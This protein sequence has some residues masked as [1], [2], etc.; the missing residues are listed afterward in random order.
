MNVIPYNLIQRAV[1]Q[2]MAEVLSKQS[3][4]KRLAEYPYAVAF[5]SAYLGTRSPTKEQIKCFSDSYHDSK[6]DIIRK[7]DR[8][9]ASNGTLRYGVDRFF[10][11]TAFPS[12]RALEDVRADN[13]ISMVLE[14]DE[15][16]RER[17]LNQRNELVSGWLESILSLD[18]KALGAWV[19]D[20]EERL[21]ELEL[22]LGLKLWYQHSIKSDYSF[23]DLYS[24][25]SPSAIAYD[26]SFDG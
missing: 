26:L 14:R 3:Q 11:L 6:P 21:T 24:M 4:S 5:F 15:R 17:Q 1:A 18:N 19:S 9:I 2:S 10:R 23:N 8:L 13:H 22:K 16:I 20:N 25:T 7:I 12:L